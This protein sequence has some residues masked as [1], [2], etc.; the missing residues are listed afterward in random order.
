M[1]SHVSGAFPCAF[2]R[3]LQLAHRTALLA[4]GSHASLLLCAHVELCTVDCMN[5]ARP[6]R[7][8]RIL[9]P[10]Q[11][12]RPCTEKKSSAGRPPKR[13][14]PRFRAQRPASCR[15]RVRLRAAGGFSRAEATT[16]MPLSHAR[17]YLTRASRCPA[18]LLALAFP[19]RPRRPSGHLP[20]KH[21]SPC[22][23]SL[24]LA[25]TSPLVLSI[26][27]TDPPLVSFARSARADR[28]RV[29]ARIPGALAS[30][31]GSGTP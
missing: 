2:V 4:E 26:S 20:T 27:P 21:F 22:S 24:S 8:P 14:A 30:A 15:A 23:S 9:R 29:P 13:V 3:V 10:T 11:A 19:L 1:S 5:A 31:G 25:A 17:L 12:S 16:W 18:V 6:M 7:S 28:C